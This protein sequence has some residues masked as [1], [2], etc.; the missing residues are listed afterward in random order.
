MSKICFDTSSLLAL[1]VHEHPNHT[2]C[3]NYY[4]DH[5]DSAEFYIASR[6]IAEIYR[7]LTS[8]RAYFSYPPADAHQLL[9]TIIPDYFHPVSL[10]HVDYMQVMDQ[11]KDLALHG[12]IIYDGLIAKSAEK[13]GCDK[14]VTYNIKD[15]QRVWPLTSADLIES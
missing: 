2:S 7:H 11:M 14:L 15:F 8:G 10:G 13:A 5:V 6:S 3:A 4:L 9:R 12:A 1:Y